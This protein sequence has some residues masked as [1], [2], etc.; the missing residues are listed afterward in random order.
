MAEKVSKMPGR[1][2]PAKM[3]EESKARLHRRRTALDILRKQAS[4]SERRLRMDIFNTW[5]T[6]KGTMVE[7]AR[8]TNYSTIWISKLIGK[9]KDDDELLEDAINQWVKENPGEEVR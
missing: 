4:I 2:G 3:D 5:R 6:G 1:P 8:A 9:I 7:I